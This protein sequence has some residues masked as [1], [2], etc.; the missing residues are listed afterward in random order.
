MKLLKS[1]RR[2]KQRPANPE[3]VIRGFVKALGSLR[4][5]KQASA[6]QPVRGK[7]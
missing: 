6:V 5:A 1:R 4:S 7:A 2:R 3:K